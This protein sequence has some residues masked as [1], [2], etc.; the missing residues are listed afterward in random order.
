MIE[1]KRRPEIAA[2]ERFPWVRVVAPVPAA[3]SAYVEQ[4]GRFAFA[5]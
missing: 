5:F 4:G 1:V 3:V 2:G